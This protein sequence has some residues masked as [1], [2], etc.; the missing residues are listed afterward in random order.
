MSVR[1]WGRVLTGGHDLGPTCLEL[2]SGRI[3]AVEAST[4]PTAATDIVLDDGWIVPGLVDLQVNGA[5]GVDLT[6][7]AEP[8]AALDAVAIVL[9]QHGVTAFCPTLVSSPVERIVERLPAL[10]PRPTA[11]AMCLGAHVEGPFIDPA[12]RGVHDP[13]VL[14]HASGDEIAR[15]L[16]AGP[17]ALV[18][19]APELPG[20]LAAIEQLCA[21]GV[22]VSLGHSGA[23]V[24]AAQ[25]G[26]AAGARMGTHLFNAMPPLHH[27]QPG[28]VGALLASQATLG[29]IADGVHLDPLVIELVV[30]LAGP[31]RVAL[32]S[33]ALAAA[34]AAPGTVALGDQTVH[35]DGVSVR[36]ANGTLAGS[37]LLLDACLRHARDWLGDWLSPAELVLMATQTPA[38][39]L[40]ARRKG[41]IEAGADA[42]LALFDS[43]WQVRTTIV[44]GRIASGADDDAY[45]VP[46]G[47]PGERP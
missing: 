17:P 31:R 5:G 38:D 47:G 20:S 19:L 8:T 7:A 34:A 41:R 15:W 46:V 36:R 16:D 40:G 12:H 3:I 24:A 9:A 45:A 30:R 37:A 32:V 44:G 35:S 27:R 6:S 18:T 23:N 14:R 4:N 1:L 10:R 42:D 2:D 13:E 28:L 43:E 29:L 26:V 39:V 33:D 22:V 11:G 21:A 25:A